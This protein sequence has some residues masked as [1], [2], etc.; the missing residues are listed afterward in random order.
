MKFYL[1][2]RVLIIIFV[3]IG[4]LNQ[5][6]TYYEFLRPFVFII[7]II[8]TIQ[9]FKKVSKTGYEYLY[10]SS[11]IL[12]NPILPIYASRDTW[13]LFNSITVILFAI[14]LAVDKNT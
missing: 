5:P 6:Y 8:L 11:A 4:I 3:F 7:S 9:A 12:F 14:S 13:L 1:L 10:L 2:G